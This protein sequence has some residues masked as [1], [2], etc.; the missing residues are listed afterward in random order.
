MAGVVGE[1]RIVLN[2]A[3]AGACAHRVCPG[4]RRAACA[5]ADDSRLRWRAPGGTVVPMTLLGDETERWGWAWAIA[6]VDPDGE[7]AVLDPGHARRGQGIRID[8]GAAIDNLLRW[9][10]RQNRA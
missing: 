1:D 7:V 9:L 4:T 2:D 3:G 10:D 8:E 5:T 6:H